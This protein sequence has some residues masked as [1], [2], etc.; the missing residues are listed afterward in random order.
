VR[1][2][3]TFENPLAA[4]YERPGGAWDV[5]PLGE[6]F[7][8]GRF[9]GV[10]LIDGENRLDHRV[11]DRSIGALA[12]S[13]GGRGVERGDVVSW[14]MPN[15]YE[16]VMLY[17]ACWLLGAIAV[18]LHHRLGVGDLA[19]VVEMLEPRVTLSA[20]GLA[21]AELSPAVPVRDGSAAF[22]QMLTGPD[23][24]PG[25]I[26]ASDIAVGVLTSGS[27]GQPKVVLHSHRG[28]AYKCGVQQQVHALRSDDVVLMPAPLSHVSGLVNGVL[29]PAFCG[30]RT[31]LMD[32]WD[33]E[34]ALGLIES[35]KVTYMGGPAVFLTGM[36]ESSVFTS[37]RV[38][39]L[40][41]SSMGGSTMTPS[42]LTTLANR[43]G[44]VVKRAYG[45]TEAPTVT[46][47]HDQ[48]PADKGRE[49][50]GRPVGEAEILVVDPTD[51]NLLG[52]GQVGEIWLRGPEMFAGY[53]VADQTAEAVTDDGWLR[54][55]DL[56]VI[57]QDGWLTV[58][59]RI[60]ELII[61]GGENIATAEIEAVLESHGAVR[62]AV[63][64]G[65]PDPILGERVAAIVLADDDFDLEEC[66]RCFADRGLAKFKTPEAVL[67]VDS[68]PML[69]TGKPDRAQIKDYAAAAIAAR[70]E[71]ISE[72]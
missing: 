24:A 42:A 37:S 12:G 7:R 18:P 26:A 67:H 34:R 54:T 65:Y 11:L 6:V 52:S 62:Q 48:D 56:G 49:T 39:S 3:S 45:S 30:M 57:D 9:E 28:L 16:A 40:R 10:A 27:T 59:G 43:L 19:G 14:Q 13:L 31:V 21:L 64:V 69:P 70:T 1:L 33:P 58:A 22:E 66:R 35:E 63:A 17:H 20:P 38:A 68:I 71:R 53:A 55:G 36:V 4:G 15:W 44:C 46:T 32:V 2:H 61:R 51:G 25:E 23:P 29:L 47:M 41:L 50:D 8:P 72:P 5:P 60:K